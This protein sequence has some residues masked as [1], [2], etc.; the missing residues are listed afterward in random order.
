MKLTV[1]FVDGAEQTVETRTYMCLA[2]RV[3]FERHFGDS[4]V[5]AMRALAGDY[6][7]GERRAEAMAGF[8]EEW[9]VFFT[10]RCLRRFEPETPDFD[11]FLETVAEVEIGQVEVG[12]VDSGQVEE[13]D[14]V[15][16]TVPAPHTSSSPT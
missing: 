5:K 16:P 7:D 8:R 6:A 10:W 14:A 3:A 12:Q 11:A 1:R 9:T 2:D 13:A 4:T 15:N